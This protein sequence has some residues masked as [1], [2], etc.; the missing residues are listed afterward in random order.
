VIFVPA[1]DNQG[2]GASGFTDA[3]GKFTLQT[4]HRG[5]GAAVGDYRVTI[6]PFVMPDGSV[7]PP[8]SKQG[9]DDVGA[10]E[11]LASR[12]SDQTRSQPKANA[13]AE[14]ITALNFDLKSKR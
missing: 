10:V 13:S 6:S 9:P 5:K 14:A 7:Y 1:G 11:Q 3:E 8:D 4:L 2:T 12:Y